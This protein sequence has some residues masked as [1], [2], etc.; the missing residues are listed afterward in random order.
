MCHLYIYFY[1]IIKIQSVIKD[2]FLVFIRPNVM[3]DTIF[4]SI[5][6]INIYDL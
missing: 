1:S 2:I 3:W 5:Q 6:L 4:K